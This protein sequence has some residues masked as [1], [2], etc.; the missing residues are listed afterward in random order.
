MRRHYIIGHAN[1]HFD[2]LRRR[3]GTGR[4][5]ILARQTHFRRDWESLGYRCHRPADC[6]ERNTVP[7]TVRPERVE[8]R[9]A[10]DDTVSC[11]RGVSLKRSCKSY[12]NT[13]IAVTKLPRPR[14]SIPFPLRELSMPPER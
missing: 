2:P 12:V 4:P 7:L 1:C 8:G 11:E 5:S 10:N 13:S 6:V 3:E 14:R 9:M